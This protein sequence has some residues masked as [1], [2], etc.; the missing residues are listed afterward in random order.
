MNEELKKAVVV[1]LQGSI[2]TDAQGIQVHS[3]V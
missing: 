1:L 2:P 3:L